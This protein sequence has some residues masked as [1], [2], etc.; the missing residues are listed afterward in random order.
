MTELQENIKAVC[1]WFGWEYDP[2]P[3]LFIKCGN[4][5]PIDSNYHSDDEA[6]ILFAAYA[7]AE[8]YKKSGWRVGG[9]Y[10]EL[11]YLCAPDSSGQDWD[12][13]GEYPCDPTDALSTA[14]AIIAALADVAQREK[15]S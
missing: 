11:I 15:E 1:E 9:P 4:N 2:P 12:G 5:A 14:T 10:P 3:F 8:A 13:T 7:T 6:T